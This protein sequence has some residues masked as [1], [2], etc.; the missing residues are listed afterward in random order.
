M[1]WQATGWKKG[2]WEA[3]AGGEDGLDGAQT[4]LASQQNVLAV[5]HLLHRKSRLR[6]ED[7]G[8]KCRH[9]PDA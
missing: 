8:S 7:G 3:K 2:S 4:V 5:R 9:K 1:G 6:M